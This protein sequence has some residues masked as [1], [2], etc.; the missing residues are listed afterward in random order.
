MLCLDGGGIRGIM[1][2]PL[3]KWLEVIANAPCYQLFDMVAGTST[4]G[5][6]AG[7]IATGETGEDQGVL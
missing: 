1:T 3:L 2:L 5:I 7:L 6:I 4:S